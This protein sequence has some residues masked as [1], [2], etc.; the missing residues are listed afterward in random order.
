MIKFK[1]WQSKSAI[2]ETNFGKI[3]MQVTIN[4]VEQVIFMFEEK[5]NNRILYRGVIKRLSKW[6]S[7]KV[8]QVVAKINKERHDIDAF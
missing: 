3:K 7:A 4:N 1:R 5:N 8:L 2:S 6:G